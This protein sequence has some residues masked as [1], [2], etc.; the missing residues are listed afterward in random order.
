MDLNKYPRKVIVHYGSKMPSQTF[1]KKLFILPAVVQTDR[2]S[3]LEVLQG[4]IHAEIMA[5]WY[6]QKGLG[7][8][9]AT[10]R[11]NISIYQYEEGFSQPEEFLLSSVDVLCHREENLVAKISKLNYYYSQG[12][13]L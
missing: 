12:K 9:S 5:S 2:K 3:D 6:L 10:K 7:T 4:K 8:N 13:D 11:E 1:G